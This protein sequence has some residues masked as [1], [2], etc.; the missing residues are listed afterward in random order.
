[1]RILVHEFVSGGGFAH[2]PV[3]RS[4][5]REGAAMRAAL[6]ADLASIGRHDIVTTVDPRFPLAPPPHVEVA[7]LAGRSSS[8]DG[9]IASVDAVWLIAP[10]TNGW[11][12]RLARRV[13]RAGK[14][15]LGPGASAIRIASDKTRLP[16][17]LA[18][19][20]IRHPETYVLRPGADALIP[21]CAIGYPVVIKPGRGA[22]CEGVQLAGSAGELRRALAT[23]RSRKTSFVLQSYVPG[24]AASVSL[25]ADGRRAVP[26]AVN[27]Q[28]LRAGRWLSYGGGHTPLDHPGVSQAIDAARR[29]CESLPGLRGYIG[30]DVVLT[31]RDAVVIE[32]N[33]R[34]TT[35][36]LG[37]RAAIEENIA[38]MALAACLGRLPAE[39]RIRHRV[40]FSA[41]GRIVSISSSHPRTLAQMDAPSHARPIARS[42]RR[43]LAPLRLR[44]RGEVGS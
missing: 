31:E 26:L 3:P 43:T 36:Y 42:P 14:A 4:L 8:L 29:T 10:E 15:L 39:P 32:V 1:M 33:P 34:L 5:A 22:G 16:H 19:H 35:S 9:L 41:A 27:A 2:K 37:V 24:A 25:L 23:R 38:D 11:L 21:A 7:T 40:R 18:K 20:G 28:H 30:V 17:R 13:E 44:T 6:V 12:E